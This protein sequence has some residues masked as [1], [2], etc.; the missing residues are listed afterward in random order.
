M[1]KGLT[2]PL[3]RLACCISLGSTAEPGERVASPSLAST[4]APRRSSYETDPARTQEAT[5]IA[6]GSPHSS[7]LDDVNARVDACSSPSTAST[8]EAILLQPERK[9]LLQRM[10]D[11]VLCSLETLPAEIQCSILAESSLGSLRALIRSSPRFYHVYRKDRLRILRKALSRTVDSNS[12]D[13]YAAY[14]SDQ[15]PSRAIDASPFSFNDYLENLHT[16]PS[17]SATDQLPL[18]VAQKMAYFHLRVVE[19]LTERYTR[20]ALSA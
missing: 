16:T 19:P 6:R 9:E 15:F 14:H 1:M 13:A 11:T 7:S 18:E 2:L 12:S 5:P 20:W 10:A 4:S 17:N 3:R 8:S